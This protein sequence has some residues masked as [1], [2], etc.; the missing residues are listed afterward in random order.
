MTTEN[1]NKQ[2]ARAVRPRVDVY[3][4]ADEYLVLADLPGVKKEDVDV[5]FEAGEL[6]VAAERGHVAAGAPLAEEYRAAPFARA[7]AMPD[8]IDA[9]KI[10]ATLEKGVLRVRLPKLAAKRPR[11]IEV[12]ATAS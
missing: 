3:E 9:D 1:V 10:D 4:N 8:G 7:F 12:R 5:R 11:K 2:N 6:H